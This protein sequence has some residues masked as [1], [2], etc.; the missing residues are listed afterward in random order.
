MPNYANGVILNHATLVPAYR[1]QED[2]VVQRILR[3][4]G[5]EVLPVDCAGIILSNSAVHCGSKTV[6]A[7]AAPAG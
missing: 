6:P 1:R 3:G 4:Y 2:A 7:R 5:Y